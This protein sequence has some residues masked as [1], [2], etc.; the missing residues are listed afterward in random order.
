MSI[1]KVTTEVVKAQK[2]TVGGK[3]TQ[4]FLVKSSGQMSGDSTTWVDA[5]GPIHCAKFR[6]PPVASR[7]P[8][9]LPGGWS[10]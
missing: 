6:S 7:L 1:Q 2:R 10:W 9:S 4:A 5:K 3:P 8:S